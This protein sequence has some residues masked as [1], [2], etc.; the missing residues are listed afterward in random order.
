MWK[1]LYSG[2]AVEIDIVQGED[3]EQAWVFHDEDNAAI[4]F[5]TDGWGAKAAIGVRDRTGKSWSEDMTVTLS[6]DGT[7]LVKLDNSKTINAP[8]GIHLWTLFLIE[9]GTGYYNAV[10]NA[11][12][13]IHAGA[14]KIVE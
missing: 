1:T 4:P 5:I 10:F 3:F 6:N 2:E 7:V 13:R 9:P 12:A 14:V 8:V 11:P